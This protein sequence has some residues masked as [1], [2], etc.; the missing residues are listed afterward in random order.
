MC[1][2]VVTWTLISSQGI[3]GECVNK[4]EYP[5]YHTECKES[6]YDSGFPLS[7]TLHDAPICLQVA[8]AAFIVRQLKL[9]LDAISAN[10]AVA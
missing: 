7:A 1:V 6:V 10:V 5:L 9:K 2:G 8:V 3:K 4:S